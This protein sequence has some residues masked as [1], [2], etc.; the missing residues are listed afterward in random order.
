MVADRRGPRRARLHLFRF[1]HD[2]P[3]RPP[4]ALYAQPALRA[5]RGRP[6]INPS[7]ATRIDLRLR[8]QLG[9]GTKYHKVRRDSASSSQNDHVDI[10][11]VFFAF[12]LDTSIAAVPLRRKRISGLIELSIVLRR[13]SRV[14]TGDLSTSSELPIACLI[15]ETDPHTSSPSTY[16]LLL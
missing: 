12:F 4:G 3:A 15:I 16:L 7:S 8:S 1:N 13:R 11:T 5:F 6:L 10:V 2:H 14:I 9:A